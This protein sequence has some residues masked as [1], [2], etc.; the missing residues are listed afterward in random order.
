MKSAILKK[1]KNN[2]TLVKIVVVN[3]LNAVVC[4]VLLYL[5]PQLTKVSQEVREKNSEEVAR[6]QVSSNTVLFTEI[7]RNDES[8]KKIS[9][10]LA[11]DSTIISFLAEVERLKSEGV[12]LIVEFPSDT[13]VTDRA[14]LTGIPVSVVFEGDLTTINLAWEKFS[15]L[16][17]FLRPVTTNVV[18]SDGKTVVN[19]GY[20]LILK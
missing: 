7:E 4:L 3:F 15:K 17:F 18:F 9:D 13:E 14:K 8:I 11:G 6:N 16:P 12:S 10:R 2:K 19:V 5:G 1:V 20:F